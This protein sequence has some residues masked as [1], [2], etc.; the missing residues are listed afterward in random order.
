LGGKSWTDVLCNRLRIGRGDARRRLDEADDL[1]PRAAMTGEPLPPLLPNVAAAQAAGAIGADHIRV[2]RRFFTDLPSAVD[3]ETRQQCEATLARIAAEHTPDA[4]RKAAER[5][6]ALV[7][8][9]GDFSDVDRARR[10][11]VIIGKQ[12]ADGMSKISG[13]LDPEARA[14]IDAVFAKWAAPGM[15]NPDDASPCVHGTPS[16]A[17]IQGDMRSPAQRNHDA[18]KAMG[19]SVLTSGQLGQ[20]NGLP[21]TIIVS[22]T[23]Q[24]LESGCGQAV[25]ATG[26]LLPM[27]TVI[28]MASH[29]YHYL[30]I[31]D[32]DTGRALHLGRTRR[33]ASADQRIVLHAR[34][35]GCTRPGCTVA[36]AYCQVHHAEK[37]WADGGNTDVDDL[38]LGC[39]QD[40][41]SVKPGGWRTRKRKDGRTEWIPPPPSRL[42]APPACG[43]WPITGQRL[44]PP[45]ELPTARRGRRRRRPHRGL[46]GPAW[47][48]SARYVDVHR[49]PR[50]GGDDVVHRTGC[51]GIHPRE[52]LTRPY[53]ADN[54]LVQRR[55]TELV[56]DHIEPA[57]LQL[58]D[59]LGCVD[60][61]RGRRAG[62][63]GQTQGRSG[64]CSGGDNRQGEGLHCSTFRE[65][66]DDV[67]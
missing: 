13:L 19:R 4:L 18:L 15:C 36:G 35:R 6:M 9:D 30:T 3:F 25:T 31:F 29:A 61:A 46:I 47:I 32:K 57:G 44:P 49:H 56:D 23:L 53:R 60:N 34:D 10:R 64:E 11:S 66:A 50:D 45:G 14:T 21:A 39:P 54:A 8:P 22:T 59:R 42:G 43:G 2:I 16:E 33:I 5:L 62:G 58:A 7:H 37:D 55:R 20:H 41:R 63:A 67:S 38:T 52:G 40:N 28:K 12:E 51:T 24:E 17:G 48:R 1:G 27:P 26:S 65:R